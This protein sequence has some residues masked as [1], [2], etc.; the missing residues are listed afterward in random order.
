[1]SLQLA[2]KGLA[3]DGLRLVTSGR[4]GRR[5]G[6]SLVEVLVA[7]AVLATAMAGLLAFSTQETRNVIL[8]EDRFYAIQALTELEEAFADKP[9]YWFRDQGFPADPSG[10]SALHRTLLDDH[11]LLVP[12]GLP[13]NRTEVTRVLDERY[14]SLG[15][16]RSVLA[17]PSADMP[18]AMVV[19]F[20]V[21]YASPSGGTRRVQATRV[22]Y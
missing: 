1:M 22:A 7:V 21:E 19:T 14:R 6:F 8:T 11:P 9:G 20:L 13:A 2:R 4:Y 15:I 17:V 5:P 18:E 3:S 16:R 10:F 12:P